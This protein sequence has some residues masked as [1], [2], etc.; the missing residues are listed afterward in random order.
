MQYTKV[1]GKFLAIVDNE[2]RLGPASV[3]VGA[4][5][6]CNYSNGPTLLIASLECSLYLITIDE[7]NTSTV[8]VTSLCPKQKLNLNHSFC[9]MLEAGIALG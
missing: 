9:Q 2:S 8:S 3:S 6:Q 4:G 7:L 5:D 1:E